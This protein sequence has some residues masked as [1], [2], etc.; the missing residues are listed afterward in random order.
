MALMFGSSSSEGSSG[1]AL[2]LR[3]S[4]NLEPSQQINDKVPHLETA[5]YH[6]LSGEPRGL[7]AVTVMPLD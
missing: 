4:L 2:S 7:Y 1:L 5:A 6:G 3:E